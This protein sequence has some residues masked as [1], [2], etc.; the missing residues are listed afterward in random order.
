MIIYVL[1]QNILSAYINLSHF[2]PLWNH[3]FLKLVGKVASLPEI[4]PFEVYG[5]WRILEIIGVICGLLNTTALQ[6]ISKNKLQALK[7]EKNTP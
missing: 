1:K 4:S 5:D 3:T 2:S 7:I 6:E